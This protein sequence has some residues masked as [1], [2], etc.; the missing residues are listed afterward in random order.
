V[1]QI[2]YRERLGHKSTASLYVVQ[3]QAG[4]R[5]K[6]EIM[7]PGSTPFPHTRM[8]GGCIIITGTRSAHGEQATCQKI[9]LKDFGDF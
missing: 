1:R 4:A 9:V 2:L 8:M 7:S 5:I 6:Y 3:S